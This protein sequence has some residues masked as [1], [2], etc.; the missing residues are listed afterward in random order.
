MRILFLLI[1]L[2]FKCAG[3]TKFVD[4]NSGYTLSINY[5]DGTYRIHDQKG[6]AEFC[7]DDSNYICMKSI[8]VNFAVPKVQPMPNKWEVEGIAYCFVEILDYMIGD[9]EIDE[10]YLIAAPE[11][12]L[13]ESLSGSEPRFLYGKKSG[14]IYIDSFSHSGYQ[15]RFIGLDNR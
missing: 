13:C 9:D 3:A 6:P 10:A 14:L 2:S 8:H 12:G 1:L 7:T 15:R 11:N 5:N 4:L